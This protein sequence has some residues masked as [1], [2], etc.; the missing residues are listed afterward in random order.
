MRGRKIP[1]NR[2][3]R[4][5]PS[6]LWRRFVHP[7][8]SHFR[9]RRWRLVL[10]QDPSFLDRKV[11]DVGGSLHFWEKVG[12]D[13]ASC[14]ITIINIAAD[15]Q[16]ADAAGQAGLSHILLYDGRTIPFADG[17][18]DWVICNSVI[19]HV[20]VAEREALVSEM[21]RVGRRFFVQTPAFAF[22]IEPHLVAPFLHWMP[23]RARY[24]LARLG[25]WALLY[26]RTAAE[27]MAYVD[28]V[29]LLKLSDMRRHFPQADIHVERWCMIPKSYVAVGQGRRAG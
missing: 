9:R 12:V 22:P 21:M 6:G 20:P 1:S 3:R 17:A 13:I 7:I 28:E 19:E 29:S 26:R 8:S 23:K 18:F 16:S 15:A 27:I 24:A 11:L 5:M 14:D 4:I 10:A 25:L 2:K